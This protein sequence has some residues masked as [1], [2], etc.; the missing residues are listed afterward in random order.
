M[1]W[2]EQ[3]GNWQESQR[4]YILYWSSLMVSQT[5]M[6]REM[7][8]NCEHFRG[9]STNSSCKI[10]L[11]LAMGEIYALNLP[12]FVPYDLSLNF[13]LS[14][15][16]K[17]SFVGVF[18]IIIYLVSD[19]KGGTWTEGVGEQGAENIWYEEK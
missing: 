3:D 4:M 2:K 11:R 18:F 19:I 9:E 12:P 10:T 6:Y 16:A 14:N 8:R 17:F 7:T 5:S 15:S 1:L 13:S